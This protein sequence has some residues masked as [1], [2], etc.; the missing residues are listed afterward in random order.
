M[1]LSQIP[2]PDRGQE[3]GRERGRALLPV[4]IELQKSAVALISRMC[5]V[6]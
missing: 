1:Q 3:R 5:D 6:K 4:K 2:L